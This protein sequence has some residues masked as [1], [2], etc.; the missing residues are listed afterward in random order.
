MYNICTLIDHRF[1]QNHLPAT[2]GKE[3]KQKTMIELCRR[4]LLLV[5]I[6]QIVMT[7]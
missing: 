5:I 3:P 4:L 1:A 7:V 2:R 6:S